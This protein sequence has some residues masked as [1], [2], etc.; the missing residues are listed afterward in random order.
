[1]AMALGTPVVTTSKGAEGLEVAHGEH[2]LIAD[3]PE[4]FAS[5]VLRLLQDPELCRQLA[6][7]ACRLISRKYDW[8]VV[9]PEFLC[10][11]ES[12]AYVN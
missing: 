12:M 2:L 3:T 10:L 1:E 11:V 7:N 5:A 6:N 8:T 9:M 4:E